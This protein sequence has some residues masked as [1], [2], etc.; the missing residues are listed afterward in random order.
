VK[1]RHAKWL[2]LFDAVHAEDVCEFVR[3]N[4]KAQKLKGYRPH[5]HLPLRMIL[6]EGID[7]Y[8]A[9]HGAQSLQLN[10]VDITAALELR[11]CAED[12]AKRVEART[13]R[14]R[15]ADQ[16]QLLWIK[17][18][19][20]GSMHRIY[21]DMPREIKVADARKTRARAAAARP[22]SGGKLPQQEKL[23]REYNALRAAHDTTAAAMRQLFARYP[24][25]NE[26]AIR[27]KLKRARHDT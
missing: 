2:D 12:L 8:I 15:D 22:R 23:L 17:F 18:I 4:V 1:T 13:A 24:E 19:A 25:V 5:L 6:M 20:V 3:E 9:D 16:L 7:S 21:D 26:T 14:R 27:R 11:R 10:R